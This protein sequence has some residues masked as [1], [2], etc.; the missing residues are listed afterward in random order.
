MGVSLAASAQP[1]LIPA[2]NYVQYGSDSRLLGSKVVFND[3]ERALPKFLRDKIAGSLPTRSKGKTLRVSVILQPDNRPLGPEGYKLTI[4]DQGAK[5]I[6]ASSAGAVH[7]G[8][9]LAQLL[10]FSPT[11][12]RGQKEIRNTEIL[13][14]PRFSWRG[15][16][17]DCSRHFFTVNEVKKYID[18]LSEHKFNVFHWHLIDDGG[19]RMEVKKYPKLTSIGAWRKPWKDTTWDYSNI[20]FGP[21]AKGEKREGGYYTQVQ[22]KEIVA[23]AQERKITVVP[24]IELPGHCLPALVTYPE[25]TCNVSKLPIRPYRT[26]AYCAGKEQTFTFL[27]N[28]LDE[29][30]K[31]FPSKII[32]IGGDEVDKIYWENCSDCKNR[33]VENNLH[34]TH[35]L[36]S[37][38]IHRIEQYLN[39]KGRTI[40]GWDEILEG[41][42]AP[43]AQVMSWRGISGGVAAAKQNHKVVMTPTSHCYFDYSYAGTST[44]H[45]YGFNPIPEELSEEEARYIEGGQANVWTE[46]I[47]TFDRVEVMIFPRM[48][49]MSEALWTQSSRKNFEDFSVRLSNWY[50]RWAES[51]TDFYVSAPEPVNNLVTIQAG[52][53]VEFSFDSI[54]G[55]T[56]RTSLNGKPPTFNSPAYSGPILVTKPSQV[57][58]AAFSNKKRVSDVAKVDAIS[59][60]LVE[61]NPAQ[62]GAKFE[63]FSGRFSKSADFDKLKPNDI[64]IL[65]QFDTSLYSRYDSYGIKINGY[66][67]VRERGRYVFFLGSDDGSTL[68]ILG[69]SVINND[70]LQAYTVR[71]GTAWLEAG[72]YPLEIRYFE[73]GGADRFSVAIRGPR[74]PE[75]K[76]LLPLLV[77][78]P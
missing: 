7:G 4:N 2:P 38:F 60:P 63:F 8:T 30:L 41:G 34:D 72:M 6:V 66:L 13:D 10:R 78:Q 25:V 42:L 43:N 46:W 59:A 17:L 12:A 50:P 71:S 26:N 67:P 33:M 76:P 69:K 15:M 1:A 65:D 49:A 74:D 68:D 11:N 21:F 57:M 9:T 23:Y 61:L 5:I 24:E 36:Q 55:I 22:I 40:M 52:T 3:P 19:W 62:L 32:H 75:P 20:E 64:G 39:K 48:L 35:E 53:S 56:V 16:H 18:Y 45:V 44:K 31:L 47:D 51:G 29:T 77:H 28:V 37:Y 14:K 27:Q 54:P 70:F 58:A 73:A